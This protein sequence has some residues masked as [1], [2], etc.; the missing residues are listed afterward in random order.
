MQTARADIHLTQPQQIVA[1]VVPH[2]VGLDI[3]AAFAHDPANWFR[4]P[5]FRLWSMAMRQL[6]H[7][8]GFYVTPDDFVPLV[9][10]ALNLR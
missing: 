9:V 6:L 7:S 3:R 10:E 5:S 4:R 8:R 2:D 1:A